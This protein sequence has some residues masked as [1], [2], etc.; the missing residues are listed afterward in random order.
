MILLSRTVGGPAM[1]YFGVRVDS[2]PV[3]V[4]RIATDNRNCRWFI[5]EIA[6]AYSNCCKVLRSAILVIVN[7]QCGERKVAMKAPIGTNYL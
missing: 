2:E 6:A 3:L 1:I 5:S 4:R 7:S